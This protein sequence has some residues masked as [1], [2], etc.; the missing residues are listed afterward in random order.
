MAEVEDGM[1]PKFASA[2]IFGSHLPQSFWLYQMVWA[3]PCS[4]I[5]FDAFEKS[6]TWIATMSALEGSAACGLGYI[7]YKMVVGNSNEMILVMRKKRLAFAKFSFMM[8]ILALF[9]IDK[10]SANCVAPL[11]M[12]QIY[13]TM[14]VGT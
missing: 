1:S 12:G 9:L 3:D 14:K 11:V 8:A 7:D 2:L 6:M 4:A 13:T 5:F 10:P